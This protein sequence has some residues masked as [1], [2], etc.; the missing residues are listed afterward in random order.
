MINV[1]GIAAIRPIDQVEGKRR[2]ACHGKVHLI[3]YP[4]VTHTNLH[5]TL[6][7]GKCASIGLPCETLTYIEGC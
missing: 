5:R 7:A 2:D 3:E 1:K 6:I 4:I